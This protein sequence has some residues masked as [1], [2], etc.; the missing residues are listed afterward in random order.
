MA[1]GGDNPNF[2][3]GAIPLILAD[4]EAIFRF[5]LRRL[6]EIETGI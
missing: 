6:L 2:N 3:G 1:P 4:S 5:G